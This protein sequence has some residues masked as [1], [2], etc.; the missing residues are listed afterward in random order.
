MALAKTI[1]HDS[2]QVDAT[3]WT[4]AT[5]TINHPVGD[6]WIVWNGYANK[7]AFDAAKPPLLQR[8]LTI[9]S[10]ASNTPAALLTYVETQSRTLAA[11]PLNGATVTP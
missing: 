7:A 8:T 6:V 5:T 10:A 3:Y 9:A 11:S 4:H 1:A 2:Q